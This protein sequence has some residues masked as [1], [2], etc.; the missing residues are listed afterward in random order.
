[1]HF[2]N[3][4]QGV[5]LT[6]QLKGREYEPTVASILL[7]GQDPRLNDQLHNAWFLSDFKCWNIIDQNQV[8]RRN[9]SMLYFVHEVPMCSS[10][11]EF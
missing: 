6:T 1:M 8:T 7:C 5:V 10:Q 11:L 9:S 4:P 2:F 3:T